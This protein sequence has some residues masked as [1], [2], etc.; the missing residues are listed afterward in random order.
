MWWPNSTCDI[1][2]LI[3]MGF[4]NILE[5]PD[6]GEIQRRRKLRQNQTRTLSEDLCVDG[7]FKRRNQRVSAQTV[8]ESNSIGELLWQA[9]EVELGNKLTESRSADLVVGHVSAKTDCNHSV[10]CGLAPNRYIKQK[11]TKISR[12]FPNVCT[13]VVQHHLVEFSFILVLTLEK[14]FAEASNFLMNRSPSV[15]VWGSNFLFTWVW[16]I[17]YDFR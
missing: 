14:L 7:T 3:V 16:R 9:R 15:F 12:V 13:T 1:I 2:L 8:G 10:T 6:H 17:S 4:T 11:I 5:D